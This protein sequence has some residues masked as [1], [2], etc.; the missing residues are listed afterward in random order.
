MNSLIPTLL[1]LRAPA[2]KIPWYSLAAAILLLI[3]A[4]LRFH[5]LAGNPINFDEAIAAFNS[6][7]SFAQVISNTRHSNSSPLLY[8]LLSWIIQQVESSAFSIRV[9]PATA[10]VLTVAAILLLLPRVGVSRP[11]ALLAALLAALSPAAV[12][13]AQFAREYSTDTLMAVLLI[14]SLLWYLRAGRKALLA[15][16]LLLAPLTQYG[17]VLFGSAILLTAL[18]S[19]RAGASGPTTAQSQKPAAY[20]T[21]LLNWL[22]RR[23]DLAIP[24]ALFLSGSLSSYFL[25]L[26]YQ[27]P[28][29]GFAADDYLAAQYY[30][31]GLDPLALLSFTAT[32]L[33]SMLNYHLPAPVL[34][35][36]L[37]TLGILLLA[38]WQRRRLDPIILLFLTALAIAATAALL[39][40]Y[41][42]GGNRQ[43]LY[44]GP[45]VFLTAGIALSGAASRLAALSRRPELRP[46]LLTG[47]AA[48]AALSGIAALQQKNPYLGH[49]TFPEIIAL[50]EQ[51]ARPA[52]LVCIASWGSD[53][54]EFY[55]GRRDNYR[56]HCTQDWITRVGGLPAL[57]SD[58]QQKGGRLYLLVRG[59]NTP[60]YHTSPWQL[61]QSS[62]HGYIE[63]LVSGGPDLWRLSAQIPPELPAAYHSLRARQPD[64]PGEFDL[65]LDLDLYRRENTLYYLKEPCLP[66]DNVTGF[67]LEIIP[68]F[69]DALPRGQEQENTALTFG[70]YNKIF[71]GKCLAAI[72][73]PEYPIA[74]I[75]A[76]QSLKDGTPSWTSTIRVDRP[77]L[78]RAA[79]AALTGAAPVAP[80]VFDLYLHNHA[81]HYV[82]EPCAPS[83]TA[84]RFFLHLVPADPA[85][86]PAVQQPYGIGNQDFDFA[87]QGAHFDGKCLALLPLP[88][89]PIAGLITGQSA[90]GNRL[91]R[92]AF[93]LDRTPEHQATYTALTGIAPDAQA[94]FDLY[95][96]D[97]N[98]HY[99]RESCAETDTTTRFFLHLIPSNPADLP[100]ERRPHGTANHDFDFPWRGAVFDGKCLATI[101]LPAYPIAG[102]ITGQDAGHG[103]LWET[104]VALDRTA[105]HRATYAALTGMAPAA[106]ADFDLYLQDNNLHYVRE[107][108]APPDTTA[109][110]FLHIIPSDPA[111]LPPERQQY[112]IDNRDFDF[113][114]RGAIFNGKCLATI[115]LPDYPIAAIRTG[116][117][118]PGQEPA[119]TVEFSP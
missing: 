30:S 24:A 106:R 55:L 45:I 17:L 90:A 16:S 71:D 81:L 12:E 97:N 40:L 27:S 114:L 75:R 87:R 35:L 59:D 42:L 108:C 82:K 100:P 94:T 67:F 80:A 6:R 102:L 56:Y 58:L 28:G 52:D 11:A 111:D 46:A 110:F 91:W 78:Y 39:Q 4:A 20:P 13:Y 105:E 74:A 117:F 109:R 5:D 89:Y 25:T 113:P 119:W 84:T 21:R 34:L 103:R 86:L 19:G 101:P 70:I 98:L 41:P 33:W 23:L 8:P 1:P 22:Q 31:G 54:I 116:Q 51:Q 49:S 2:A 60:D 63:Q 18:L 95:L 26:R 76:G 107:S 69:P 77:A 44:L 112:G 79:W 62:R 29:G 118:I 104:T 115:T 64:A 61:A 7:G 68:A 43:S 99:V 53:P 32:R 14:A 93:P 50:L 9:V 65:Y 57:L 88:D 72:T 10:S 37:L 92:T 83:D 66:A 3:A 85:D 36:T 48:L 73:L 96:Q 15:A 38:S 47:L